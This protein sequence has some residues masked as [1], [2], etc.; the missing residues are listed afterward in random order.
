MMFV[1]HFD[2]YDD[3]GGTRFGVRH[4]YGKC[5]RLWGTAIGYFELT[6]K[7]LYRYR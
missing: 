7:Y 1:A 6:T 2:I 3:V 5:T 4:V